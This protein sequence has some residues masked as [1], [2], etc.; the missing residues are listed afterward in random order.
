[1]R[2]DGSGKSMRQELWHEKVLESNFIGNLEAL[3]IVIGSLME[4]N[5]QHLIFHFFI[6]GFL[7]FILAVVNFFNF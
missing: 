2:G 7:I 1:M 5:W 6:V 4:I 3:G